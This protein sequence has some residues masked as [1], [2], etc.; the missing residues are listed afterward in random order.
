MRYKQG[1]RLR[2]LHRQLETKRRALKSTR[3]KMAKA[4][5]Q[6]DERRRAAARAVTEKNA[7]SAQDMETHHRERVAKYEERVKMLEKELKDLE[8]QAR[9][10]ERQ[11]DERW[12]NG[13]PVEEGEE[14]EAR[15]APAVENPPQQRQAGQQQG[16]KPT[17]QS[18]DQ[19]SWREHPPTGAYGLQ[20]G[21]QSQQDRQHQE[22]NPYREEAR[23]WRLPNVNSLKIQLPKAFGDVL[24]GFE[25]RFHDD[26]G[27][28]DQDESRRSGDGGNSRLFPGGGMMPMPGSRGRGFVR[29]R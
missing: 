23:Q 22:T 26:D 19:N 12:G 2:S 10:E 24:Q 14:V 7:A 21:S 1:G 25:H 13:R 20:I 29:P 8:K 3:A 27:I 5:G 15:D 4:Q 16:Q 18:I 28:G 9:T 17:Q 11:L 6:A